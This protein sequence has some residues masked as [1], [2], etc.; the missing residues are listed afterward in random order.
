MFI[1]FIRVD[2]EGDESMCPKKLVV[3]S[4]S[5]ITRGFD[6]DCNLNVVTTTTVGVADR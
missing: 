4:L 5:D 6:F 1:H 2:H 3:Y